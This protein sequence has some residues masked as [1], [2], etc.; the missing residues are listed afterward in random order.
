MGE[1][2]HDQAL[3]AYLELEGT[4]TDTPPGR[5]L[6]DY[7]QQQRHRPPAGEVRVVDLIHTN[8]APIA[9]PWQARVS[10]KPGQSLCVVEPTSQPSQLAWAPDGTCT[11]SSTVPPRDPSPVVTL[12]REAM[13][14]V[15]GA[16][17]SAKKACIHGGY[18][19][20]ETAVNEALALL[21]KDSPHA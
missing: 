8:D 21:P 12:G 16:L 19:H 15:R 2:T 10:L 17:E 9:I 4:V 6:H 18:F 13:E 5:I 7:I 3:E 14:K 11:T 1:I 20:T